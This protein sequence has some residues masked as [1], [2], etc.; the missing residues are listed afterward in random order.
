MLEAERALKQN[1]VVRLDKRNI[2][3]AQVVSE[4]F[5]HEDNLNK[6]HEC[7]C[8]FCGRNLSALIQEA[9]A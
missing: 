9:K 2:P 1:L 8:N 6:E 4:F 7:K 3:Y 5:S